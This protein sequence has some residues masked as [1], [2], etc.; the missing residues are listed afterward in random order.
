MLF[1]T[2]TAFTLAHSITLAI[3]TLGSYASTRCRRS[4]VL[5]ALSILFSGRRDRPESGAGRQASRSGIPWIVAFGLWSAPRFWLCQRAPRRSAC[6]Q[7]EIIL[8]LLMFNVGVEL[9]Q[10][11]FVLVVLCLLAF[12][13]LLCAKLPSIEAVTRWQ[14]VPYVI[15]CVAAYWT[16]QRTMSFLV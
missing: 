1:K 3:A 9:G 15:G 2:I 16:I 4:I 11:A 5:I 14:L 12:F 8:A 7:Q 10:I 13:R 6:P